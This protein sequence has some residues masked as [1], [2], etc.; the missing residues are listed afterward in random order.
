MKKKVQKI[1][2]FLRFFQVTVVKYKYR[3]SYKDKQNEEV[4]F[5]EAMETKD[6]MLTG[7]DYGHNRFLSL[8]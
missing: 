8:E 4:Y 2:V 1:L 7:R 3:G 6:C 5:Y